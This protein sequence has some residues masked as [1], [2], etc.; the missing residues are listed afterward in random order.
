MGI[1]RLSLVLFLLFLISAIWIGNADISAFVPEASTQ[2][3]EID[4]LIRFLLISSAFLFILMWGFIFYL[5]IRYRHRRTDSEETLGSQAHGNTPLEIT[6]SAIPAVYLVVLAV[7]SLRVWGDL[8]TVGHNPLRATVIGHQF[9]Y[10]F[11]YPSLGITNAPA[12]HVVLNR[13]VALTLHGVD[14][15]H[16]F[17][18]PA[19]RV[20][21]QTVPGVTTFENFTPSQVGSYEV[22]CTTYCGVGHSLM[23]GVLEV[24]TQAQFNAWVQAEKNPGSATAAV[25]YKN[26]V[27]P[28]MQLH[29]AACHFSGAGFVGAVNLTSYATLLEGGHIAAGGV[30]AG[31]VLKAGSHTA[32]YLWQAINGTMTV[33]ARMPLGGPYLSA[34]QIAVIGKWIDQG[35]KNN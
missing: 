3:V 20:Q 13:P 25:S 12:L 10:E 28:I 32:S 15:I 8:Q 23:R 33:G 14:V 6:W 31:P 2:A 9:Y 16:S 5:V 19:L 21:M 11:D 18:V 26:D 4:F 30:L 35:A 17:W 22:V 34:Q 29:C 27:Y 1:R 7:L 24:D